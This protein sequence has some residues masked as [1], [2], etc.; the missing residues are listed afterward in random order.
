MISPKQTVLTISLH[1]CRRA[2]ARDPDSLDEVPRV[3]RNRVELTGGHC[4]SIDQRSAHTDRHGAGRIQ[5]PALS[6]VTPPVGMSRT[7]GSGARMSLKNPG[8]SAVA[9]NTLTMSAPASHAE[10]ISVGVKQP[11]IT[12][13]P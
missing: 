3:C 1:S 11:G 10:R 4:A 7:C 9:G 12:A 13:A 8:P 5:S 2:T 6:R